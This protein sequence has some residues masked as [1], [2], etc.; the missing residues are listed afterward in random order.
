VFD[1]IRKDRISVKEKNIFEVEVEQE[2]LEIETL[3]KYGNQT[4]FAKRS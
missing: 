4:N 2:A 3:E 1:W